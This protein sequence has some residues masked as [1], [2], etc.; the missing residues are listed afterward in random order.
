[1]WRK[2]TTKFFYKNLYNTLKQSIVL[3]SVIF[4]SYIHCN[5]LVPVNMFH[6][7]LSVRI[8]CISSYMHCK[9]ASK[10]QIALYI[11]KYNGIIFLIYVYSIY[12]AYL[13][14]KV[15]IITILTILQHQIQYFLLL[16]L[17]L[18]LYFIWF[19]KHTLISYS[20]TICIVPTSLG[21][22]QM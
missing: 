17:L 11:F 12:L 5:S 7:M 15:K 1:M 19:T 9:P 21:C 6:S 10:K 16:L 20:I 13:L 3:Y 2:C 14:L 18:L 22:H 8:T 4:F